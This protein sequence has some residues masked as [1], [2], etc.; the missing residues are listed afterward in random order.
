MTKDLSAATL[1][2]GKAM[3]TARLSQVSRH[4]LNYNYRS[5]PGTAKMRQAAVAIVIRDLEPHNQQGLEVLLIR[6]AEHPRDPWSGHMAFPGGRVDQEDSSPF[7]AAQRETLEEVGLS[8]QANADPVGRLS[9]LMVKAHQRIAP[10]VITPYLFALTSTT[11]LLLE[12]DEVQEAIWVPVSF[13]G[14]TNNRSTF[15]QNFG[16]VPLSWPCCQYQGRVVWGLTLKMLD[17]LMKTLSKMPSAHDIA[18]RL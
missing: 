7:A 18:H 1:K 15:T 12:P 6:R 2:H 17:E 3:M 11:T 4:L 10:M 8:L 16:G 5:L 14:D 9:H 13:F